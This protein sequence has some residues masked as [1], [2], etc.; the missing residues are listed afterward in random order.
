MVG[1]F[2]ITLASII[3]G[4][5]VSTSELKAYKKCFIKSGYPGKVPAQ[6]IVKMYICYYDSNFSVI[7]NSAFGVG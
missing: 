6:I 4:L 3:Y 1:N 2:L 7:L 5:F